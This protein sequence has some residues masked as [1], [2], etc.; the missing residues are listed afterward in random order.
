[1]DTNVFPISSLFFVTELEQ[2][3]LS[4]MGFVLLFDLQVPESISVLNIGS[5]D[6]ANHPAVLLSRLVPSNTVIK[7]LSILPV[8]VDVSHSP[9]KN[10]M[11]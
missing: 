5:A 2:L 8:L 7:T 3:I 1:M 10:F 4:G 9:I 6:A 11:P